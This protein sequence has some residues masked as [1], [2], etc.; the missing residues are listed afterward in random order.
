MDRSSLAGRFFPNVSVKAYYSPH[1][2]AVFLPRDEVDRDRFDDRD[3][4]GA[5][6]QERLPLLVHEF[7]HGL[8]HLGTIMG[9]DLLDRLSRAYFALER[10]AQLDISE[11]GRLV[12]LHD[13]ERLFDRKG[14]FTEYDPD[15]GWLTEERPRWRWRTSTGIG[16]DHH[17]TPDPDDPLFFIRFE[18]VDQNAMVARQP[19]TAAALFETRAVYAELEQSVNIMLLAS[20]DDD[21]VFDR[22]MAE[23]RRLLYEPRLLLYSAPAHY[24]SSHC[25]NGD[26]LEAYKIAAYAAGIVLNLAPS[27]A[28]TPHIHQTF[29]A[30][31]VA[32]RLEKLRALRDPGF[33]YVNLIAHGGRYEGDILA[34]LDGALELAG[35]PSRDVLLK[36]AYDYLA[37]PTVHTGGSFDTMYFKAASAGAANFARL[38]D[39]LGLL[40]FETMGALGTNRAPIALPTVFTA[41]GPLP[42][43]I[44]S[45]VEPRDQLELLEMEMILA[46]Q[47]DEFL[48]ACR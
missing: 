40:D 32:P 9:R 37:V 25:T 48:R 27:L 8:D 1:S 17:G 29:A 43:Q 15:Y 22:F 4:Y 10:K 7:Q 11:I 33:L 45:F 47:T 41:N 36:A 14:Y 35:Y 31:E 21:G 28:F 16:F 39:R 5:W 3:Y 19:I 6:V 42:M 13:A 38:R 20:R 24:A 2:L 34:W 46:G 18:D 12:E 23:Q 26:V 30:P 44:E